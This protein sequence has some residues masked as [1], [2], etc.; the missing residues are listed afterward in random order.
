M[1]TQSHF[2]ITAAALT[3]F[4]HRSWVDTTVAAALLLGAVLPDIPFFVLT[5]GGEV[6][7]R[8]L[9][10]PPTTAS[11]MEYLHFTLFYNDPWWIVAHN[12]FHSLLINGAL[13]LLGLWWWRQ[14][15]SRWGKAFF[16]LAVSMI[17]HVGI[18]I[19]THRS[20]GPL[21]WFPVN[22][23][24]RFAS[25]ISYWETDAGGQ[26][27]LTFEIALNLVLLAYLS[28]TYWPIVRQRWPRNM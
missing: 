19:F 15:D 11:I 14:R 13:L 16:W 27:F 17:V 10:S 22:W 20:D 18:D 3:P 8:W 5:V 9:A 28:Y 24:Y 6:Y 4:R 7:Y 26:T 23:R 21:I 12:F 1:Q 2:L 25:P